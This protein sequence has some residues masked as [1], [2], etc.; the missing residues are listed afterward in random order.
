MELKDLNQLTGNTGRSTEQKHKAIDFADKA[1]QLGDEV[2]HDGFIKFLLKKEVPRRAVFLAFFFLV[3]GLALFITG[4]FG[5]VR[6]WDPLG[7]FL[8]W[9]S[10]MALAIPGFFYS[11]KVVQAYRAT[12]ATVRSNILREIPD[13]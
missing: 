13:M 6:E 7:G 9:G 8:F 2:Q 11:N 1:D 3:A 4:F 5:D 10:G 12:D